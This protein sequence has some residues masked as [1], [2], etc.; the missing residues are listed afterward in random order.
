MHI[1][2]KKVEA[3]QD[4]AE[5]TNESR[6]ALEALKSVATY[7]YCYITSLDTERIDANS[8]QILTSIS[9]I[10]PFGLRSMVS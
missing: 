5:S 7:C 4:L 9:S 6:M 8:I 1:S 2:S 3:T 10:T